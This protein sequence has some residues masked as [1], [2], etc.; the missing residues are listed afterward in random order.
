MPLIHKETNEPNVPISPLLSVENFSIRIQHSDFHLQVDNLA[1]YPQEIVALVGESGSGKSLL[2]HSLIQTH[3]HNADIIQKGD[4]IFQNKSLTTCSEQDLLAI[5]NAHIGLMLQEPMQALNPLHSIGQQIQEAIHIHQNLNPQESA[6]A[7]QTVL[8][9][10]KLTHKKH[11]YQHKLPH[12]LS[13]GQR[14][15]ALL[16][17]AMANHP[18]LLIADEPTTALDAHTQHALLKELQNLRQEKNMALLVISHDLNMVKNFADRIIVM[19]HGRIIEENTTT[20]L[21]SNPQHPITK[22]LLAAQTLGNTLVSIPPGSETLLKVNKLTASYQDPHAWFSKP[23]PPV[24]QQLHLSLH[25]KENL[26]IIGESGSGKTSL[27]KAILQL[28][29]YQGSIALTQKNLASLSAPQLQKIRKSIQ[30][31]YQDPFSS[32]NP[33]MTI[34]DIVGEGLCIHYPHLSEAERNQRIDTII[35]AVEL[36]LSCKKRYPHEFSGGQRQRIAIARAL[37]I[38]PELV[39]LD[40]PTTALDATIQKQIILLLL[41]LQKTRNISFLLITHNCHI[42]QDFCHRVMV[43]REGHFVEHG[44]TET[45]FADPQHAYTKTLLRHTVSL[46]ENH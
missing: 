3:R 33:R 22:T 8:A 1:I 43:M 13:G 32:L 19:H 5:R 23:L 4:I 20:A 6:K 45:V 36:P 24:L 30:M 40:E 37:V 11:C 39:I 10:A 16:A 34:T 27:A 44:P 26:G 2:A 29:P 15:R 17:I 38:E 21:F 14:Q 35:Q 41:S 18:E 42:V 9:Q 12:E 31:V 25:K 7:L 28:I 46:S